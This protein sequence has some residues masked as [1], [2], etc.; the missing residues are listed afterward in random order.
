ML[1]TTLDQESDTLSEQLRKC[2]QGLWMRVEQTWN[3]TKNWEVWVQRTWEFSISFGH[4]SVGLK[5]FQNLNNVKAKEFIMF[6]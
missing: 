2:E 1:V 4:F 5:L 6:F 3:T